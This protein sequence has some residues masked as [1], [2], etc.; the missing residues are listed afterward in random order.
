MSNLRI[1]ELDFDQIKLNLKTFMEAQDEFTDYDFEGSSLS[2]LMDLLA[3]NTHYNA[4][5]A[6]MLMNEMFLDSAVKRSSAVSIAK[7]LGYTPTSVRGAVADLSVVITSP[8]GL[9]P[10]LTMDRYTQF[11]S[12]IDGT[13]FTFS[14]NAAAT[15]LRVGTTY[16]FPSVEAIEG[17]VLAYNY[18]ATDITPDTKYEIPST[19]VDTTTLQVTV[20]TS[21]TDTTTSIY[22]LATD[23]TGIDGTSKIFF[24]EQNSQEKY[25]IYFGDGIIGKSLTAGNIITVRYIV[26]SGTSANVSGTTSQSF[27][28]LGSI[29][30][31]ASVAVTVNSNSSGG[32]DAESI[33]S[34]KFNAPKVNAAG[35]RLVTAADYEALITAQY[36]NF[37]SVSVWG[38]EENDPPIYGKVIISLKPFNG[39]TISDDTKDAI[40][41]NTLTNKKVLAIQP[42]FVDPVYLYINLTT[43]VTYNPSITTLTADGVKA[44][45]DDAITNYFSTE[46]QKFNKSYNQSTLIGSIRDANPAITSVKLIEKLQR[47]LT[48]VLN[49]PNVYSAAT[50]IKYR[51]SIQPG[52][53]S[54]S[55]FYVV[56]GGVSVL[57]QIVDSPDDSPPDINGMG[58]LKLV[59]AVTGATVNTNIG[60]V[61]YRNGILS[62]TEIT[63][64][65]FPVDIKEINITCGL[66]TTGIDLSISKNEIF[67]IDDSTLNALG[68]LAAGAVINMTAT[69]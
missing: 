46:L 1:A 42:M 62:I 61:D 69:V 50:S 68:G 5:L 9:P 31:A 24:L 18:V 59:N 29:G 49:I 60:T 21:A 17:N 37:E 45:V 19:G 58:T 14:T 13:A 33:S 34:I 27:T 15:A 25:Q 38:G 30:G 12:T 6:N 7:H 47:R 20:Q 67:V 53:V 8:T 35:N 65:G 26:S 36:T 23:I 64:T 55:Y 10:T 32:A 41:R 39:Y 44:L 3:Y 40:I 11:T 16:T 51:N 52:Y 4:Y 54:S 63:P 2:V 48:V 66:Q 43:N 22:N 56:V 57:V 28:A